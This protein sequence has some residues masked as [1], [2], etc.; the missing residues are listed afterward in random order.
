MWISSVAQ[1]RFWH[2][3]CTDPQSCVNG[4]EYT[5]IPYSAP[6][7]GLSKYQNQEYKVSMW[8]HP[9]FSLHHLEPDEVE[10]VFV[11]EI[12]SI[13]PDQSVCTAFSI[14]YRTTLCVL[15]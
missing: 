10:D 14:F 6:R 7:T 8:L 9:I 5:A 3:N 2:I 15:R 4:F 11:D 13:C 1:A 12:L